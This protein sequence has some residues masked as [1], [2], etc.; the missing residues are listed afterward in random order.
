MSR[1]AWQQASA[2]LFPWTSRGTNVRPPGHTACPVYAPWLQ[3]RGGFVL[4][5][6]TGQIQPTEHLLSLG[7]LPHCPR[8]FTFNECKLWMSPQNR[9]K[10]TF[11]NSL[12]E[13]QRTASDMERTLILFMKIVETSREQR[14][15][16]TLRKK[17]ASLCFRFRILWNLP[18]P[19]ILLRT[20]LR[21]WV[22][23]ARPLC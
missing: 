22:L 4:F 2:W 23:K 13:E 8:T 1:V 7:V 5:Y 18:W 21:I 17:W 12:S 15:W 10:N 20:P 14:A 6:K 9:L 3:G 11:K 16:C 19:C